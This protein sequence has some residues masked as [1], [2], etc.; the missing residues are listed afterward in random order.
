[1]RNETDHYK[2]QKRGI[3]IEWLKLPK[4]PGRDFAPGERRFNDDDLGKALRDFVSNQNIMAKAHLLDKLRASHIA[5]THTGHKEYDHELEER[6]KPI[7]L[8]ELNH[9]MNTYI[10]SPTVNSLDANLDGWNW[11]PLDRYDGHG[12]AWR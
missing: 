5:D 12:M 4:P 8:E 7:P 1:M 6:Q 10:S 11:A 2:R 9:K 3:I